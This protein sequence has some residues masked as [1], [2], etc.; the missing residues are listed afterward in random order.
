MIRWAFTA[1]GGLIGV[2]L[3]LLL[4][5]GVIH[6]YAFDQGIAQA[7]T[8]NLPDWASTPVSWLIG[9][10][11]VLSL[12]SLF[13]FFA[14]GIIIGSDQAWLFT[15]F[16]GALIVNYVGAHNTPEREG[17]NETSAC[18][19]AQGIALRWYSIERDG[20]VVLWNKAGRHPTR[21]IPLIAI[22]PEIAAQ[23]QQQASTAPTLPAPAPVRRAVTLKGA[24]P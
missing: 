11:I 3:L 18:F 17:C 8:M 10:C 9:A 6:N 15:L 4:L 2:T 19:S 14:S 1:F 23:W 21:N 12:P 5:R 16:L 7:N 24:R 13:R 22:T 20:R